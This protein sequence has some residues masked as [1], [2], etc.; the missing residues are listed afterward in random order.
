MS[1]IL[2]IS[3]DLYSISEILLTAPNLGCLGGSVECPTVDFGSGHDPGV[4]GS[5]LALGS[6]LGMEPT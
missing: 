6:E 3:S 5:N 4:M 2:D 1:C